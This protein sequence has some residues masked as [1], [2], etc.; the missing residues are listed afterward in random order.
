MVNLESEKSEVKEESKH[1]NRYRFKPSHSFDCLE[2]GAP[3]EL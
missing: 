1:P 2:N 3:S